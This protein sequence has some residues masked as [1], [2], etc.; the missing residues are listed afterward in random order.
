MTHPCRIW[1]DQEP[2]LLHLKMRESIRVIL[3]RGSTY[4]A[5]AMTRHTFE[6]LLILKEV[7]KIFSFSCMK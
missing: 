1:I 7:F 3:S 4:T 6:A 5:S 2:R